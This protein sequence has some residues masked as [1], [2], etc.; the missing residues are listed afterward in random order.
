MIMHAVSFIASKLTGKSQ[1]EIRD[2]LK[3]PSIMIIPVGIAVQGVVYCSVALILVSDNT[4][5][6]IL[7]SYGL[8]FVC[9]SIVF[10]W[11][12]VKNCNAHI[13]PCKSDDAPSE[14]G[15]VR[16]FVFIAFWKSHWVDGPAA[17]KQDV[18]T[19]LTELMLNMRLDGD[20][21]DDNTSDAS[22]MDNINTDGTPHDLEG[23]APPPTA[24]SVSR[25]NKKRIGNKQQNHFML[26][27][28]K[29]AWWLPLELVFNALQG[30][31]LTFNR[32]AFQEC[33][34]QR[35]AILVLNSLI[36]V[37]TAVIR[38]CGPHLDNFF[39]LTSK[40]GAAI[41]SLLVYRDV[42][43][44]NVASAFLVLSLLDSAVQIFMALNDLRQLIIKKCC[45]A[46]E[47]SDNN[48]TDSDRQPDDTSQTDDSSSAADGAGSAHHAASATSVVSVNPSAA[49]RSESSDAPPVSKAN[50]TPPLPREE[51][52]ADFFQDLFLN[53]RDADGVEAAPEPPVSDD[54]AAVDELALTTA[55]SELPPAVVTFDAP[56]VRPTRALAS[57]AGTALVSEED[58]IL[59]GVRLLTDTVNS[60][61]RR[62]SLARDRARQLSKKADKE[63][64]AIL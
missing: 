47:N 44:E 43:A 3:F 34:N 11:M 42:P 7:A 8:L 50:G 48:D 2:K 1:E 63:R 39:L 57:M 24:P 59:R 12:R 28:Q 55:A 37:F 58:S 64:E 36:L 49:I 30:F 51:D 27:D 23:N 46:R 14:Y 52:L 45:A 25:D 62:G 29:V 32:G 4:V 38:P 33:A 21:E 40:L 31:I 6:F 10:F 61:A 18:T 15:L 22:E 13:G 56:E 5:D 20:E 26:Q 41:L 9:F 54:V 53:A 60:G 16:G 19:T 35:I 17:A